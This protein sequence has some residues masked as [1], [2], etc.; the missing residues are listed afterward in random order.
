MSTLN[1][2]RPGSPTGWPQAVPGAFG[3]LWEPFQGQTADAGAVP[4]RRSSAG[5]WRRGCVLQAAILQDDGPQP[6]LDPPRATPGGRLAPQAPPRGLIVALGMARWASR[7]SG[8]ST[9]GAA[10]AAQGA[11]LRGAK[12]R[13]ERGRRGL[14]VTLRPKYEC[15]LYR[16]G[17]STRILYSSPRKT[18][19]AEQLHP[20]AAPG[21]PG[22]WAWGHRVAREPARPIPPHPPCTQSQRDRPRRHWHPL[23]GA[24]SVREIP[25]LNSCSRLTLP[26]GRKCLTPLRLGPITPPFRGQGS[27]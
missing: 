2:A 14:G 13:V 6:L 23:L 25:F 20:G 16:E 9:A 7:P 5:P 15:S 27:S 12:P 11:G 17:G 22:A 10:S 26:L 4:G 21:P 8:P 3:P 18:H 19:Q 1:G 24:A